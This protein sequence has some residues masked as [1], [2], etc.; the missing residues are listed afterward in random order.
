[1]VGSGL[2]LRAGTYGTLA[3]VEVR[4]VA[5]LGDRSAYRALDGQRLPVRKT[6]PSPA[7]WPR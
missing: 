3:F 4:L 5:P 7:P 6:L 1:V 2:L